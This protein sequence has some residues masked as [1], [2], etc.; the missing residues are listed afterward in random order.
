M[1]SAFYPDPN[2]D[3]VVLC[4]LFWETKELLDRSSRPGALILA[5]ARVLGYRS[6]RMGK[7]KVSLTASDICD[8]FEIWMNHDGVYQNGIYSCCGE[9]A[10]DSVCEKSWMSFYLLPYMNESHEIDLKQ[11]TLAILLDSQKKGLLVGSPKATFPHT[12][13]EFPII[14][15]SLV[16]ELINK[17]RQVKFKYDTRADSVH[18]AYTDPKFS[19][20]IYVCPL[21]WEGRDHLCQG[22]R[23]GTIILYVAQLL[24]Y[25]NV[26]CGVTEDFTEQ[27]HNMS[28]LPSSLSEISDTDIKD[29]NSPFSGATVGEGCL[30]Q[31]SKTSDK[32]EITAVAICYAF[33]VWMNHKGSY[34]NG[35][36]TCCMESARYSVCDKSVMR[37]CVKEMETSINAV[38]TS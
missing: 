24:G 33:E 4:K 5:T 18:K 6:N 34:E 8:A 12:I 31:R 9:K 17:V 29:M 10:R 15:T 35:L 14:T 22:S 19:N 38:Q 2:N 30:S 32:K 3:V 28:D 36:Y 37:E 23:P 11:A 20:I 27:Q 21:F 25:Q 7:Y 13:H 1:V 16:E 26:L